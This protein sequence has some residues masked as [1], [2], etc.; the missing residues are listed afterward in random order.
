MLLCALRRCAPDGDGGS[1]AAGGGDAG[2]A[3]ATAEGAEDKEEVEREREACAHRVADL[4][5][6]LLAAQQEL[7]KKQHE[8]AAW[9]SQLAEL[10]VRKQMAVDK[11]AFREASTINSQIKALAATREVEG[12]AVDDTAA[13]LAELTAALGAAREQADALDVRVQDSCE[14]KEEERVLLLTS[15]ARE[16]ALLREDELDADNAEAAALLQA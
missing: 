15:Q 5:G 16:L 10:Q 11:R 2:G 13:S 4:S 3:G 14:R 1:T 7:A 9:E 6:R 8:V 12:R